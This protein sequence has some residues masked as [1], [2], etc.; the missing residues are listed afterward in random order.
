MPDLP[1]ILASPIFSAVP[2]GTPL[3]WIFYPSSPS[4]GPYY[5]TQPLAPI[6]SQLILKRNPYYHG[7]RPHSFDAIVDDLNLQTTTAAQ[8]A[9]RGRVDVVF[10]PARRGALPHW[11]PRPPLRVSSSPASHTTCA[12]RG[13]RCST[14]R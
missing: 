12:S 3:A 9:L 10:D 14:S 13:G 8:E 2:E 7:P 11:R 1:Q 5:L 6:Q 4:A